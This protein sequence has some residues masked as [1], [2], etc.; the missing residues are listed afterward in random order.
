[1]AQSLAQIYLHIVFSTKHRYPWLKTN[2]LQTDVQAYLAATLNNMEC[3]C[4][5]AGGV[6]DHVHILCRLG[7][8]ITVADLVRDV[9]KAS[10]GMLHDRDRALH[11]DFIGRT[12]TGPSRSARRMSG[13]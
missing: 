4:V 6:E 13:R 3:P 5:I 8:K 7:R 9:K 12:D 2:Q 11:Q 1:M 10:S